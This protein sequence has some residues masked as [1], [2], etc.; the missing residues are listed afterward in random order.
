MS[1]YALVQLRVGEVRAVEVRSTRVAGFTTSSSYVP[2]EVV[3][4]RA[5]HPRDV[6]VSA[7]RIDEATDLHVIE[8][9]DFAHEPPCEF[10]ECDYGHPKADV[11]ILILGCP[12]CG[13]EGLPPMLMCRKDWDDFVRADGGVCDSCGQTSKPLSTAM[14]VVRWLS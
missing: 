13:A 3:Q 9:L 2:R 10:L 1:H 6:M 11:V 5:G 8:H 12:N 14:R 7:T 4:P